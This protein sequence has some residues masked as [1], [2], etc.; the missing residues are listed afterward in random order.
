MTW[1]AL[2][3]ILLAACSHATWN[4]VAKRAGGGA[5]FVWLFGVVSTVIYLPAALA[6]VLLY[7]PNIGFVELA[8]IVGSGVLHA[9]YFLVLQRGYRNGDL[10][11][12]YPV[13][14]GSGPLLATIDAIACF[15]EHPPPLALIGIALVVCGILSV[16]GLRFTRKFSR[17][18]QRSAIG[19]GLLTG[20]FIASYTLW[21]KY[22]VS[23]L[24]IPA[25]VLAWA[26][27]G[28]RT[29][30]V[31][32]YA[33]RRWPQVTTEWHSHKKAAIA[34]GILAPL[35]YFLILTA[36]KFTP[37]SYVASTREISIV[38]G[39]WMGTRILDEGDFCRRLIASS[40]IVTG[41]LLLAVA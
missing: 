29:L 18:A 39:T 13:A 16:T 12:V 31:S 28:T 7:K 21:D 27:S 2:T 3:L 14:R 20:C 22:A 37:V 25:I 40:V 10:S 32:I 23:T 33:I 19:Y 34:V 41:V 6:I 9:A 38:I 15:H 26:S 35:A 24:W 4:L 36:L 5:S 17:A 11:L 1:S 30:L 8:F